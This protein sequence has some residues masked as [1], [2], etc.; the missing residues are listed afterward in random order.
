DHPGARR[1]VV[2]ED[3]STLVEEIQRLELPYRFGY[4]VS[5]F[6][7]TL[8]QIATEAKGTWEFVPTATGTQVTWTYT[9]DARSC[10]TR[11]ALRA[12]VGDAYHPYMEQAIASIRR[13]V[14]TKQAPRL[15][16]GGL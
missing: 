8:G 2:L 9:F 11:P 14:E 10:P 7:G 1:V 3:G 5:R 13:H 4:R 15:A 6:S 12:L 16:Q